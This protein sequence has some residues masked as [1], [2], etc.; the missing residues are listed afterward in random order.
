MIAILLELINK[1]LKIDS[2]LITDFLT[3]LT[4]KRYGKFQRDVYYH[5]YAGG[6]ATHVYEG[7]FLKILIAN[8]TFRIV[9]NWKAA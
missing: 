6:L 7:I 2:M 1:K 4:L 8:E 3:F 5:A 9:E